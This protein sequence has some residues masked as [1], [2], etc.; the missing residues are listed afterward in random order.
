VDSIRGSAPQTRFAQPL[1]GA[2]TTPVM[3]PETCTDLKS[4]G[5]HQFHIL[6]AAMH[7]SMVQLGNEW[8]G[9]KFT[10]ADINNCRVNI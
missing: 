3:T 4:R 2:G 8:E 9:N 6:I 1:F 7:W 5:A 10:N